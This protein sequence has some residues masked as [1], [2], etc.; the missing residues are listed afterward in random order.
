MC[1]RCPA[2]SPIGI[3]SADFTSD[4]RGFER[5]GQIE[6]TGRY[7]FTRELF[8]DAGLRYRYADFINSEDDVVD[9][10]YT[11]DAGLGYRV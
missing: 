3:D 11:A 1:A 5:Y 9:H 10:R 2:R 4:T 8:G 6:I 7:D